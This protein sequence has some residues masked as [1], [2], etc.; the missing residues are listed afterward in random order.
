MKLEK[1]PIDPRVVQAIA[2]LGFKRPTDIQFKSIP[3]ILKGEDLFAIAQTGTGKTAA[4]A[5]PLIDKILKQKEAARRKDGVLALILVPSHELAL[6]INEVIEQLS[7]YT[8]VYSATLI[9]GVDQDPQIE[10]LQAGTD[11]VVATPGRMFDL[12]HQGH[13]RTH[14]IQTLI[15]DEADLML[16]LGFR[17]DIFDIIAKLPKRKQTLF[18]SA[19]INRALKQTAYKIVR[20]EAI[21]IQLSPKDPVSKNVDHSVIFVEMDHKRF[22]L[23]RVIRENP[24][25]KII[26]FARTK[27]RVER[28]AKAMARVDIDS[29]T[30]HGDKE[31][32]E[33]TEVLNQF[34]NTDMQLLIAT[35]VSAR[36]LDIPAVGIV[37]NYDLP[38]LAENYVHRIG[39]TG[40]GNN[41]G[42]AYSFCAPNEKELLQEIQDYIQTD[43]TILKLDKGSYS[44]TLKIDRE[45]TFDYMS[46]V[47]EIDDWEKGKKKKKKKKK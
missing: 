8:E 33:R 28:I 41:R 10:L 38:D 46:I 6:Q 21:R 7:V 45:R 32:E 44:D 30:I 22:F 15:L 17:R 2:D 34:A 1:Y 12:I 18:F 36:G 43:I 29:I 23:E 39:R 13:L 27:V 4:F 3:Y 42:H 19:T 35:D 26:T 31:Q 16:D 11:I 25:Q 5:I 14:R 37:V 40:R 47:E 9:G 20:Q 24:D